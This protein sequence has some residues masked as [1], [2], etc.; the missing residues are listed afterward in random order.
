MREN[1]ALRAWRAGKGTVGCWLSMGN[2]YSAESLAQ[3]GF[4]WVCVDLQHGLIDY[5]DLTHMLPAISTSQATPLVRVP[6]NEPYE[7]MKA[8]DAGAYGVIVPMVNSREEAAQAVAACRYPPDGNR[9]FGPIRAALYGGRGYAKEANAELACIAMI[10]TR[11]GIANLE[12]ILSTPGL[13]GV[14]VGPSDLALALGMAPVG[15]NDN[16]EHAKVVQRILDGCRAHGVAAGIH[17]S[18]LAFTQRYLQA[19]FNF[20]TLGTDSGFMLGA[21]GA[22]LAAAKGT[23]AERE[24]TGY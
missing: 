13:D 17:T 16:P 23:V 24:K 9:S 15:D 20:V 2:S 18:S 14:Y 3:M 10:E 4:D 22:Q 1:T 7:I 19:G 8:L 6:W 12:E 5:T 11:D 21:A